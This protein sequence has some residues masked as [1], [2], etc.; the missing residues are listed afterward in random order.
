[1]IANIRKGIDHVLANA[2]QLPKPERW[3]A[4]IRYIVGK[5]IEARPKNPPPFGLGQ[6]CLAYG[7]G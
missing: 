2:P 3:R 6:P 1:M 5:I 7:V 4:L